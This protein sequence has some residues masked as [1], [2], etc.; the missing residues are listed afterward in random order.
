MSAARTTPLGLDA[1]VLEE[2]G[3]FGREEGLDE[4]S[5]DPAIGDDDAALLGEFADDGAVRCDK[6]RDRWGIVLA[7]V[8]DDRQPVPVGLVQPERKNADGDAKRRHQRKQ[9]AQ[10]QPEQAKQPNELL[11]L[12]RRLRCRSRSAGD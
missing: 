9:R 1:V 8:I 3:V 10:T 12:A 11:R 5:R 7:G 6:A 2:G 4:L